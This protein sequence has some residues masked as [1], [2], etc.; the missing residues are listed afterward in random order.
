M[1]LIMLWAGTEKKRKTVA[2]ED[3]YMAYHAHMAV[4]KILVKNSEGGLAEMKR[5]QQ[6]F[7]KAG[8]SPPGSPRQ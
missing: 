1:L 4:G 7:S 3:A 6:Q 2:L 8:I 5:P